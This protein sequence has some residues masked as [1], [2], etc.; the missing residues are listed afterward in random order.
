MTEQKFKEIKEL[1]DSIDSLKNNIA[2][3]EKLLASENLSCKVEGVS[4]C[5]LKTT[6]FIYLNNEDAIRVLLESQKIFLENN[7]ISLETK[8]SE[9]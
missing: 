9:I 2:T 3:I 1:K 7:L 8:F 5:K 4:K 6:R